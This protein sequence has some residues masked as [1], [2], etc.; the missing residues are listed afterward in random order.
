[1]LQCV[2]ERDGY[3]QVKMQI[4]STLKLN[5]VAECPAGCGGGF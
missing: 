1:V 3:K 5:A 2:T 4:I